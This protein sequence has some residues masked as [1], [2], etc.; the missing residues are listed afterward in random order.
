MPEP[1]S[2]KTDRE[3]RQVKWTK[4]IVGDVR[5]APSRR[6]RSPRRLLKGL[7]FLLICGGLMSIIVYSPLFTLQRVVLQGNTYMNGNG[8]SHQRAAA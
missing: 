6:R 1:S 3:R 8:Y 5:T 7:A 4:E 2:G